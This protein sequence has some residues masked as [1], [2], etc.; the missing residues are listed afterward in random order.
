M[1]GFQFSYSRPTC[2]R[3]ALF[4][5]VCAA[6]KS[7]TLLQNPR[8]ETPRKCV[9]AFFFLLHMLDM[10]DYKSLGINK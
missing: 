1:Q 6:N 10:A 3:A 2:N 7:D 4:F 5:C 9:R 8:R